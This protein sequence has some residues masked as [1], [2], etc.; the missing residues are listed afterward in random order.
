MNSTTTWSTGT[1]IAFRFFFIYFLLYILPFPLNMVPYF[2]I[3]W[4]P[5]NEL[6]FITAD[7]VYKALAGV[8]YTTLVKPGN[9]SGDT[10]FHYLEAAFYG[11]TAVIGTIIWTI[12]DRKNAHYEKLW[13]WFTI[14]LRYYLAIVLLGYGFAKVIKTQF[15]FP[16]FDR[17]SQTYGQ[18]S[19]MGL[20]WTFMGYSTAYNVFTGL[21]EV[22]GGFLLFFKRTRVLGALTVIGV[23][24]N[25]VMLNFSYDV[26]VKLFSMHLLA[27]AIL[28][29]APDILRLVRFLVL[30]ER[31][32]PETLQPVYKSKT[33]K[34]IYIAAKGIAISA[35]IVVSVIGGLE[36]Q[37]QVAVF[38]KRNHDRGIF[39]DYVVENFI[40]GKDTLSVKGN[41][42]RLW[43]RILIEGG[44]K[45]S[46][47]YMDGATLGWNCHVNESARKIMLLSPDV[48]S[49]YNFRFTADTSKLYMQGLMNADSVSITLKKKSPVSFLLVDRG[50]HWINESPFNR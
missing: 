16:S 19:P 25:V 18:S 36:R 30:N 12:I 15:P 37:E 40:I 46:I 31:V 39:G 47:E 7:K 43:K 21:W 45:A 44:G 48:S 17:L 27:I 10:T 49:I 2:N 4:G 11:S 34:F 6:F 23:M 42:T 38:L 26:P 20:L 5:V 9:G 1:K 33:G 13:Y 3:V 24:S 35:F 8:D 50:F 14:F 41:E 22:L 32:E 28:L 29:L